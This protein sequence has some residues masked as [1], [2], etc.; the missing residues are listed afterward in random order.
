MATRSD[1]RG[2]PAA[3]SALRANLE[4]TR[5]D[6]EIPADYRVLLDAVSSYWGVRRATEKLLSELFHPYRNLVE[7]AAQLRNLCG[8]MFHYFER[9]EARLECARLLD[10]ILAE[11]YS[12]EPPPEVVE[13]VVGSH[14]ELITRIDGSR[15]RGELEPALEAALATLAGLVGADPSR[16]LPFSGLMKR[17]GSRLIPDRPSGLAFAALYRTVVERGL[18][19]F[20]S[21]ADLDRWRRRAGMAECA[22]RVA[23]PLG[24]AIAGARRRLAEGDAAGVYEVPNLDDLLTLVLRGASEVSGPG[25]RIALYVALADVPELA[26]REMEILRTLYYSIKVVCDEGS[27]EDIVHAV[28]LVTSHLRDGASTARFLLYKCLARL[29]EGIAARGS[30]AVTRHLVE[31]TIASGFEPPDIRGVSEEWEVFVNP[32]HLPCLRAWLAIVESD[33]LQ[34]EELL[35]ALV[36]NLHLHGVF[37]ADTDLFQRDISALLNADIAHAFNLIIQLVGFFPVFFNEVGSEGELRDVS[38]RIDQLCHRR[39]PVIHYLRKQ[40]HAESNNRLVGF[41]RAVWAWWRTGDSLPLSG[42]LPPTILARLEPDVDWFRGMSRIAVALEREVGICE[43]DLGAVDRAELE[44]R[45]AAVEGVDETD[46]ER[47][48]LLVRLVQLLEAK[49]SLSP[50]LLLHSLEGSPLVSAEARSAFAA[51]CAGDDH[52]AVVRTGNRVLGELKQVIVA[53]EVTEAEENIFYKRHIAAGI[54]SMYGTYREPKFDA[55][56]LLIR[57]INLLRPHLEALVAEFNYR[58]ITLESIRDAHAILQQMLAGLRVAGLRVHHLSTKLDLLGSAI[59]LGTLSTEQYLNVFDFMS[60]ALSDVVETN[61]LELHEPNLR[62]MAGQLSA[63]GGARG[64][65]AADQVSEQLFRSLIASTY[66]IQEMD[67]LLRRIRRTL[68]RMTAGLS[69]HACGAVLGYSPARLISHLHDPPAEHENQLGLGYKGFSLK[70]LAELG[71]PVPSG[72]V[73]STEL[74]HLQEALSDG[75]IAADTEERVMDA[76]RRVELASG[77]HLGDPDRP[78]LLSV[79]SGSAFSMPGMMLT[80]LNVGIAPDLVEGMVRAGH[81]AWGAWDCYRRYVQNVAMAQGVPRDLFDELMLRFKQRHGVGRKAGFAAE[82][83]QEMATDYRRLAEE[84]RVELHDDPDRQ[85]MQAIQLV[86]A[87]WHSEP[88]QLFRTQLGYSDD[89]G[90]AVIVQEM[91]LGNLHDRSGSG[92]TFTRDPRSSTTGI[93]LFGDFTL[94]SQGEDVV[95]GLVRPLPVSERQRREYSA[96][97]ETSLEAAFPEVFERLR[98][99]SSLLL[100]EHGYEH[101]EIEFTFESEDPADL[102]LLQVRPMRLLRQ[103]Q[104][105]VFA[106]PTAMR[107]HLLGSGIGVSGGAMVGRVA[108]TRDD[109]L[110][111]RSAHPGEAVILLRPD[112]VPEDIHLVVAVDGLLTARGGFTS[113]AAV[114]AKRLGKCCVVNCI[115][116]EVSES[117]RWAQLGD[118]RLAPGDTISIDG[119]LGRV[120]RG[121]HEVTTSARP[122]RLT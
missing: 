119:S 31:R 80:I 8:G 63:R 44:A 56:G 58:Y 24:D 14:L 33:P 42:F 118:T 84:H 66:A 4:V 53:T 103:Q 64:D 26:H 5:H 3:S 88:A 83:M 78:L 111:L 99:I 72:F 86:L 90:T 93:G 11:L 7:I 65:Q 114:T 35:S 13:S 71:L 23:R 121:E 41:S 22:E 85:L 81:P 46:R 97:L 74:Y 62:R 20:A 32:N 105:Q 19:V 109:V 21:S 48:S 76:V 18:E 47:A 45:I 25:E 69:H 6:V 34:F 96:H 59:T 120:F 57:T 77:R 30:A 91:K 87:S 55:M 9:S 94:R 101:Q 75:D 113:H 61:Y 89:W 95:G 17:V 52:L 37:V 116:L 102:Y 27:E 106:R 112:T 60:E 29:G 16:V 98:T 39:D 82:Q 117:Q 122:H 38:T 51:A 68:R 70:R 110:S 12:D 104:M 108:F 10:R 73:I 115:D 92:V 67:L 1:P 40:C 43:D 79:R 36:I 28:D 50:D 107:D 100:N 49:Y 15:F 2:P 54:P